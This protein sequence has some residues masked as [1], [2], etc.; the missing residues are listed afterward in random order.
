MSDLD[1]DLPSE[2]Y[3]PLTERQAARMHRL[4]FQVSAERG[5]ELVLEGQ[6][7]VRQ[8]GN[9]IALGSLARELARL[10]TEHEW[11]DAI[12]RRYDILAAVMSRGPTLT[13]GPTD[14][15]LARAHLQLYRYANLP[16]EIVEDRYHR[17]LFPGIVE[18]LV[19]DHPESYE[20]TRA[21]VIAACGLQ[22]MLDAAARNLS[23]VEYAVRESQADITLFAGP[24][25]YLAV[26]ARDVPWVARAWLDS[27]VGAGGALVVVPSRNHLAIHLVSSVYGFQA[28]I[29]RLAQLAVDLYSSENNPVSSDVFWWHAHEFHQVT[30]ITDEGVTM[31]LT[32]EIVDV[33]NALRLG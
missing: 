22:P 28:S 24:S 2:E 26:L 31:T 16:S 17:E 20:V 21:E 32:Q 6:W 19:E 27:E 30:K 4:C 23:R 33:I 10:E 11:L 7:L 12:N 8:D 9:R 29:Q 14:D 13:G 25:P 5:N 1:Q 3:S 18:M 15:I